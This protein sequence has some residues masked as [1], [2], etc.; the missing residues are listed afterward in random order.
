MSSVKNVN[1][2]KELLGG[3]GRR[4]GNPQKTLEQAA[5]RLAAKGPVRNL[6]FLKQGETKPVADL[7]P[8]DEWRKYVDDL[9]DKSYRWVVNV[10]RP[11]LRKID[12][13]VLNIGK[14]V[15]QDVC[16]DGTQT[17]G[18]RQRDYEAA[19][20][21]LLAYGPVNDDMAREELERFPARESFLAEMFRRVNDVTQVALLIDDIRNAEDHDR[22]QDI[23]DNSKYGLGKQAK[24]VFV[25]ASGASGAIR[26]FASQGRE[27][28]YHVAEDIFGA[29]REFAA[30]K[31]LEAVRSRRREFFEAEKA[32]EKKG[33]QEFF[34]PLETDIPAE[35]IFFGASDEVNEKTS[36]LSWGSGDY[37]NAFRLRR[38]GDRLY[39]TGACGRCKEALDQ[40]E[41]IFQEPFVLLDHLISQDGKHLCPGKMEGKLPKYNF[42]A[43]VN[44]DIFPLT[45]RIRT[46]AGI[47]LP[48]R[49]LADDDT[50]PLAP[51]NPKKAAVAVQPSVGL[52]DND[53]KL[54][55]TARDFYQGVPGTIMVE[56][57]AGFGLSLPEARDESQEVL[58]PEREVKLDKPATVKIRRSIIGGQ[59]KIT[60]DT[61][62]VEVVEA[63]RPNG[64]IGVAWRDSQA[65]HWKGLPSPIPALLGYRYGVARKSG[66]IGD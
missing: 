58:A 62:S 43:Y 34:S 46:A 63:L 33:R 29:Y 35:E 50:G 39:V 32:E 1:R 59:R 64:V 37:K 61:E 23:L 38:S 27:I 42:G 10:A 24:N 40:A 7:I 49:L 12:A 9:A 60:I 56:L 25:R 53:G 47:C 17:N 30:S 18:D 45:C 28:T 66:E 31:V 54:T 65:K 11:F 13:D 36:I 21:F 51:S 3:L 2:V 41:E 19:I 8:A 26:G 57:P 52:A 48:H 16:E 5:Q 6:D 22:F 15:L 44:R 14:E 20:D 55:V 4:N